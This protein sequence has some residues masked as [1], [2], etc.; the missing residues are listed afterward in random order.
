MKSAPLLLSSLPRA[1][2][3]TASLTLSWCN[4]GRYQRGCM[5]KGD[6][7]SATGEGG[8]RMVEILID[9]GNGLQFAPPISTNRSANPEQMQHAQE[10]EEKKVSRRRKAPGKVFRRKVWQHNFGMD[11]QRAPCFICSSPISVWDF[12]VGHN[13]AFA[14]G[15]D[16]TL[17][18]CLPICSVCNKSQGTLTFAEF[19]STL[20]RS[21]VPSLSIQVQNIIK[22]DTPRSA[23]RPRKRKKRVSWC[24]WQK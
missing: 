8:D 10:V 15:G 2:T 13:K 23:T 11:R 17:D 24:C 6:Q 5:R 22:Q 3:Q 1:P 4:S 18:N 20:P 12:E 16:L 14:D 19:M 9:E 21:R 7:S